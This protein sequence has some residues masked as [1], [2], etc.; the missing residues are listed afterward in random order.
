MN[1][2][3][4]VGCIFYDLQEAFDCV[5]HNI[6][7]TKLEFY[8]IT[9]TTPK[10]IKSYMEGRYQKMI[11]DG[12]IPN[13]NSEWGEIRHGVPQGSIPGPLLFLLFT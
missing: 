4:V 7:L 9:G 11:L 12:N 3:K 8:G 5:N 10:L 6:L 1:E 2:R 13:S